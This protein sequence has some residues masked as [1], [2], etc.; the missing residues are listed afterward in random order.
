MVPAGA[1]HSGQEPLGIYVLQ[2]QP[3]KVWSSSLSM[4]QT[5]QLVSVDHIRTERIRAHI[6]RLTRLF[7]A[8]E[9]LQILYWLW[10]SCTLQNWF[11]TLRVHGKILNRWTS[12]V[13]ANFVA[14]LVAKTYCN[15]WLKEAAAGVTR[16]SAIE[17]AGVSTRAS[18]GG[19]SSRGCL[20][21]LSNL[22]QIEI[23][24]FR[25]LSMG[26]WPWYLCLPTFL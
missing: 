5:L 25:N 13:K 14:D 17:P 24:Q 12:N 2:W 7:F 4:S 11:P 10:T 20:Q 22:L 15:Q 8:L 9:S 6:H 3:D 19:S 1:S 16:P 23:L 26:T 18:L 21:V